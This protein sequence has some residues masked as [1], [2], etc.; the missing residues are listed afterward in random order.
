MSA[1]ELFVLAPEG[2][3][4]LRV[5]AS[6]SISTVKTLTQRRRGEHSTEE[7]QVCLCRENGDPVEDGDTVSS[8]G[9]DRVPCPTLLLLLRPMM[10]SRVN[11]MAEASEPTAN[12]AETRA[13]M[14]LQAGARE[15]LLKRE[16]RLQERV[17]RLRMLCARTETR[18]ALYVQHTWRARK[19]HESAEAEALRL[20]LEARRL[21]AVAAAEARAQELSRER[22]QTLRARAL[23]VRVAATIKRVR[24]EREAMAARE[25]EAL[26][27]ANLER[28]RLA[29][30]E[31]LAQERELE[32]ARLEAEAKRTS[33]ATLLQQQW[34]KR[35][36]PQP[37]P[38]PA[39]LHKQ[40]GFKAFG[41]WQVVTWRLRLVEVTRDDVCYQH[42]RLK[43]R[44]NGDGQGSNA[45]VRNGG[46][47][48]STEVSNAVQLEGVQRVGV[49]KR[50][51]LSSLKCVGVQRDDPR[52][53]ILQN[54]ERE[55]FFRLQSAAQCDV[56]AQSLSSIA[57][58][59]AARAARAA[60]EK[61]GARST[62]AAE[63]AETEEEQEEAAQQDSEP[64][65]EGSDPSIL[66]PSSPPQDKAPN[67]EAE[68]AQAKTPA[69]LLSPD[70]FAALFPTHFSESP[71]AL[72]P[73]SMQTKTQQHPTEEDVNVTGNAPAAEGAL[74]V[75]EAQA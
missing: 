37:P 65:K 38:E 12:T 6:T 48:R 68:A 70:C 64:Q 28:E 17:N 56:W 52:V 16:Q 8:L 21:E 45:R 46:D 74:E 9:L 20:A 23:Q 5:D 7:F 44:R 32:R 25:R 18:A 10:P 47:G 29:R 3:L 69:K 71:K 31:A 51:P 22:M 39:L 27:Y 53:L 43:R 1:I 40:T 34:R 2:L 67:P 59:R 13:A 61:S 24:E 11:S 50:I 36:K 15:L 35:P 54:A 72:R 19:A 33:S 60:C 14:C 66:S 42:V 55:F 73:P 63:I 57:E 26:A 62:A 49:A 30:E 75:Q 41:R 58:D 4:V